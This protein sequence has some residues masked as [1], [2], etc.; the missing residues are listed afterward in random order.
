MWSNF[1]KKKK[2]K[3]DKHRIIK[4]LNISSGE[5]RKFI[6]YVYRAKK[7]YKN[8]KYIINFSKKVKSK[9]FVRFEDN[10]KRQ[11]KVGV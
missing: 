7:V 4:V 3:I 6:D 9:I 11:T 10:K 5:S 1:A 2:T 8:E